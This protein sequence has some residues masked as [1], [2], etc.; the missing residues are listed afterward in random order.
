MVDIYTMKNLNPKA[1]RSLLPL[2]EKGPDLRNRA[3]PLRNTTNAAVT[4]ASLFNDDHDRGHDRHH[5]GRH[6]LR[7]DDHRAAEI[8]GHGH[9]DGTVRCGWRGRA[10]RHVR[11]P[12]YES[13]LP[14]RCRAGAKIYQAPSSNIGCRSRPHTRRHHIHKY[15]E[16]WFRRS[17]PE[18]GPRRPVAAPVPRWSPRVLELAPLQSVVQR[19]PETPPDW[20]APRGGQICLMFSYTSLLA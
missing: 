11:F 16:P 9:R 17:R 7:R 19:R 3:T 13:A 18:P 8:H 15:Q 4:V 10:N 6:G 2:W 5:D 20:R 12:T 1:N 14:G